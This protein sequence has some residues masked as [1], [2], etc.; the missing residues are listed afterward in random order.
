MKAAQQDAR[1]S[2]VKMALAFKMQNRG[3]NIN[4]RTKMRQFPHI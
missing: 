1:V 2:L 3:W 4:L